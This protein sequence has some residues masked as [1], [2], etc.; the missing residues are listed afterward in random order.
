MKSSRPEHELL[1]TVSRRE[2]AANEV[3]KLRALGQLQL[4]WDY[5]EATA[6][7]HGL[8][9]LL[10]EHVSKTAS[11]LVP[12]RFLS[13]LKR[14][15]V[16]N[17]QSVLHLLGKALKAI[18]LFKEN[19]IA[20][21]LFK[22]PVLS[23]IAYGEIGLRQAGDIDILISRLDFV[24]AKQLLE[25]LGYQMHPQLTAVQQT[26]HLSFHC[27]IQFMRDDWF[28]VVDLHWG[29][30]P[31]SFAFGLE[32]DEVMSRLQTIPIAGSQIQTFSPEDLLIYQAM[33]GAKHLWRRLEWISSLAELISSLETS[34]WPVVVARAE[35]VRTTKMVALGLRLAENLY[36]VRPPREVLT[37]LDGDSEMKEFSIM[38][39]D[40]LFAVRPSPHSTDTHR[41]S[42]KIMDRKRDAIASAWRAL[43]VPTLSDWEALSL[44]SPLHSLYYAF[45]PLRLTR[46]YTASLLR[47]LTHKPA[48]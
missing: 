35:R 45:R 47:K 20:A 36:S 44:P 5:L 40:E 14:E 24:P 27:E 2:L 9:P 4:D 41:Y 21:A 6:R 17:A 15:S 48:R 32:G 16:T 22:G 29:L 33:H 34:A 46:V 11:D 43:F 19:G 8:I 37:A 42:F 1:L 3:A 26:S 38:I 13:S 23:E 28:T 30:A 10:S 12:S 7:Q 31:R 25:S 18:K 39:C